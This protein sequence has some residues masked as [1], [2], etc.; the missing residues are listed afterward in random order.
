VPRRVKTMRVLRACLLLILVI[1][2]RAPA[3]DRARE[4]AAVFGWWS[5]EWVDLSHWFGRP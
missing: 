4:M 1:G 3:P 2:C 5:A